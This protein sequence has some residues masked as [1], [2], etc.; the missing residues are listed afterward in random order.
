M[1]D[2][3]DEEEITI[4]PIPQ[5]EFYDQ[6]NDRPLNILQDSPPPAGQI[7]TSPPKPRK[8]R[9]THKFD[10]DTLMSSNGL[11]QLAEKVG[12][13]KQSGDPE[14]DLSSLLTFYQ[15]WIHSLD[16][17]ISFENGIQKIEKL[18]KVFEG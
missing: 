13:F 12:K 18:T 11:P 3:S 7:P 1:A 16:N 8:T 15:L 5:T 6:D 10:I 2:W 9:I 4:K 14:R 17:K